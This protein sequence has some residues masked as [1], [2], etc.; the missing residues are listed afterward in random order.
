MNNLG[1]F[2]RLFILFTTF[3]FF[4]PL[5]RP[6][7]ANPIVPQPS[8]NCYESE[9]YF[10][11]GSINPDGYTHIRKVYFQSLMAFPK[12]EAGITP[13]YCVNR[14]EYCTTNR[15]TLDI[16]IKRMYSPVLHTKYFL[17][18]L[19]LNSSIIIVFYLIGTL[20]MQ[21]FAMFFQPASLLRVILITVIGY[22]LDLLAVYGLA[23]GIW[24]R[25][26]FG[27]TQLEFI[28]IPVVLVLIGLFVFIFVSLGFY[29]LYASLIFSEKKKKI[30]LSMLF[31]I[32]SNPVWY[33]L[34]AA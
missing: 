27:A 11:A 9:E 18:D 5:T 19:L 17:F 25:F 13:G 10:D 24:H 12:L 1:R 28:R 33:L 4:L 30:F 6:V 16:N 31:G 32:L 20:S 3:V 22:T 2:H 34:L 26:H 14:E 29:F 21:K 8:N 7:F 15:C 23:M